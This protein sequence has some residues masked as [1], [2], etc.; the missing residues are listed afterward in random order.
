LAALKDYAI[1]ESKGDVSAAPVDHFSR[2]GH[3]FVRSISGEIGLE[4]NHRVIAEQ[5]DPADDAPFADLLAMVQHIVPFHIQHNAEAEAIDLLM[6]LQRL[7][8]LLTL[9][10]SADGEAPV[11]DANNYQR[12]ALYLIKAADYMADPDDFTVC[13]F[14]AMCVSSL[15]TV[16]LAHD[17]LLHFLGNVGNGF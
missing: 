4:Y 15:V 3:E 10:K 17:L 16:A 7:K 12:I 14:V 6:E 1:L 2:W 5:A 8:L 11:V 9:K 13:A